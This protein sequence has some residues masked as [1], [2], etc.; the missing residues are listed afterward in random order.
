[1]MAKAKTKLVN[2]NVTVKVHDWMTK[3]EVARELRYMIN[4]GCGYLTGKYIEG[5]FKDIEV[6]KAVKIK[7]I[8]LEKQKGKT[9]DN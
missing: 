5:E 7:S 9:N 6:L 4:D 3:A 1:M 8:A 2:F